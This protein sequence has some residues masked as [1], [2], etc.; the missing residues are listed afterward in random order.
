MRPGVAVLDADDP[1]LWLEDLDSPDARRWVADRNDEALAAVTGDGFAALKGAI[2]EV[3][4]SKDR[5]P[6]PGWRGDGFYYDFWTDADHPRGLWRRTTAE[7]SPSGT[8]CSTSTR[9][10]GPSRRAGPGA[11]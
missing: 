6:Y 3:L 8:C 7:H 4:D 11:A 2:R 10:T 9:S 1:Y 5:I